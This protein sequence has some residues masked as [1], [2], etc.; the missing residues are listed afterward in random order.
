MKY[1]HQIVAAAL[2]AISIATV[3]AQ[4]G[5]SAVPTPVVTRPTPDKIL[6]VDAEYATITPWSAVYAVSNGVRIVDSLTYEDG[7]IEFYVSPLVDYVV[8]ATTFDD[9]NTEEIDRVTIPIEMPITRE[10]RLD[11]TLYNRIKWEKALSTLMAD[12][13][14]DFFEMQESMARVSVMLAADEENE[15]DSG[16]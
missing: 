4:P 13:G 9:P 14:I 10:N 5:S 1:T 12:E 6:I 16:E 15:Q 2:I 7:T 8:N 11:W 3:L